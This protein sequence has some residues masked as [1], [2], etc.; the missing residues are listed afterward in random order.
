MRNRWKFTC[1]LVAAAVQLASVAVGQQVVTESGAISGVF[2][3]GLRVYK[4]IPFAAPP[5][6]DLRWRPPVHAAPWTGTRKADSFAP[7]CM[8]VGVS[9]PGETTPAVSEDC[10]Y[11]NIW[12]PA[13]AKTAPEHLPV[14]VWI[15]GGGYINGS[16]SMPL[17]WGDRLAQKGVVVVTISYRL[18]PLGFL[19]LPE[20]TR[21]SPHHSSGNYGLMDQIAALE[22]IQRNIAA[23]GGDP[24]C[25]TIA[26]QSSG[27]ISVSIL[28]VSPL[29]KGLFQRAIGRERRPV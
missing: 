21:E 10:L 22:W 11:L 8:Q 23:F 24:K 17:Y 13:E 28:M 19:A 15:Y 26:G 20:L 4:G 9:M 27:S 7:A 3:N 1:V 5:V 25:V 14:I 29:A 12:T 16:A 6:G 2:A 18:G